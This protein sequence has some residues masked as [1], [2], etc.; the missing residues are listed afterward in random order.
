MQKVVRTLSDNR[1]LLA[2]F[3]RSFHSKSSCVYRHRLIDRALTKLNRHNTFRRA[4]E[5]SSGQQ[6]EP[7][8]VFTKKITRP[9]D[10]NWVPAQ[11]SEKTR[12][13][14]G[15]DRLAHKMFREFVEFIRLNSI[16]DRIVM[17]WQPIGNVRRLCISREFRST[18]LTVV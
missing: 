6:S 9:D 10:Q 13:S 4:N 2:C 3:V 7:L 5:A 1:R 15:P 17:N 11:F 12:F 14:S 16:V 18:A 8:W